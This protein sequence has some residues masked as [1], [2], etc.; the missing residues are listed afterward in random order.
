[1][2]AGS[3][4]ALR[5]QPTGRDGIVRDRVFIDQDLCVSAGACIGED[6]AAFGY[7]ED[8]VA[9]TLP[10]ASRLSRDRL[11]AIARMCPARAI[12]M[13]DEHGQEVDWS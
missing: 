7:D 8:G 2:T 9:E 10:G 11:I 12:R 13:E 1:L 5:Q 6:P 3:L 4:R